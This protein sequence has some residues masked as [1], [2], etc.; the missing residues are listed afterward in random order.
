MLCRAES[1]PAPELLYC[2]NKGET[3]RPVA[4]P[5]SGSLAMVYTKEA[6][7]LF[8]SQSLCIVKDN[9]PAVR[10]FTHLPGNTHQIPGNTNQIP[11]TTNQIPGNF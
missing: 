3:V 2:S 1:P 8:L 4:L 11:G 7:D 6:D 5:A 9:N 10:L